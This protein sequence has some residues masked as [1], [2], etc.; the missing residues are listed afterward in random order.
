MNWS[1][2]APG[3]PTS[4]G[5]PHTE[6]W[7]PTPTAWHSTTS[8]TVPP[9]PPPTTTRG[10]RRRTAGDPRPTAANTSAGSQSDLSSATQSDQAEHLQADKMAQQDSPS[11][12]ELGPYLHKPQG[13][14]NVRRKC[15]TSPRPTEFTSIRLFPHNHNYHSSSLLPTP[16]P[17][18]I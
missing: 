3:S 6:S 7:G 15:C 5:E 12:K 14:Q 18:L 11:M 4:L 13:M 2:H 17:H 1:N 16:T 9:A 10:T 8:P